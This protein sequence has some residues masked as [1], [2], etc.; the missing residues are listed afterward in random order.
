MKRLGELLR[1]VTLCMCSLVSF[2]FPLFPFCAVFSTALG[3]HIY[4]GRYVHVCIP[5]RDDNRKQLLQAGLSLSSVFYYF[6]FSETFIHTGDCCP[7]LA[8]QLFP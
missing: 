8:T 1:V 5:Q 2:L 7:K 3:E 6:N 4:E